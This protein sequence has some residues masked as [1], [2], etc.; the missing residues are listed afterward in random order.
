MNPSLPQLCPPGPREARQGR[1]QAC[2]GHSQFLVMAVAAEQEGSAKLAIKA[3]KAAYRRHTWEPQALSLD[4][5]VMASAG[6][7]HCLPV[8]FPE[9]TTF[10]NT[11]RW[12]LL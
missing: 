9:G 12:S 8:P 2:E 7:L 10:Q 5:M 1:A 3:A 4:S 11:A 6:D